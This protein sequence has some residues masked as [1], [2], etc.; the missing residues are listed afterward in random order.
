MTQRNQQLQT[1]VRLT[2]AASALAAAGVAYSQTAP[3][4]AAALE[5]VVITGSRL[6]TPNELSISPVIAVSAAD[7]QSRGVTRIEDMLTSLPQIYAAQN[8][9]VSNGADGT[10]TVSLRN[11]GSQR[12]LVLVNGRRLGPGDPGG[13]AADLNQIPTDLVERVE[14]LTG[15]ASSVYGADAV[16]GV[17]NFILNDH[18][19][20]FK[21]T[22]N[23]GFNNHSQHDPAGVQEVLANFNK[24]YNQD[25][26]AAPSN[27]N[28]GQT[29]EVSAVFGF[30]TGD[31]KGNVTSY[32]TYRN[33]AAVLQS[34]YDYSAATLGSGYCCS[35]SY[36][37]K[38]SVSGSSTSYPGRARLVN[39]FG[40]NQGGSKVLLPNAGDTAL[41]SWGTGNAYRFN[42]GP[43]NYQQR[44]DEQYTAGAMLH[45]EFNEHA[46]AYTEISYINDHTL[47]QI[48]PSGAF[49]GTGPYEV[50]CANPL[51]NAAEV[52]S[53]CGGNVNAG[54]IYLLLGRRNVEGGDRIDD[55][56]HSAWRV[57]QGLKGKINDAWDYD[58]YYSNSITELSET[59]LNDL[60]ISRLKN[61]LNVVTDT[62]VGSATY[63]Q[64]VC[65]SVISGSDPNCVPYNIWTPGQVTAAALK[66]ISTP[67]VSIGR[68]TQQMVSANVTG[69]LGKYGVKLPMAASGL[70]INFGAE[71]R[72][73]TSDFEPDFEY[74]S[75][76]AAGSGSP[77]LPVK[78]SVISREAFTEA[79]LPILDD[80]PFAKALALEGGYR[81]SD[82]SLGFQ[83]N[84]YKLGLEWSPVQELR[85]RGSFARA[86]RAPNISELY[87]PL[88]VG[89]DGSAD[90]CANS[91][92]GGA[93]SYTPAQCAALGV[94]AG[95]Y[96]TIDPNPAAQYN[97]YLGGNPN[98]K[99]ET[100]TTKSFG[101]GYSPTFLPGF[102]AQIDYYDIDIANTISRVGTSTIMAL[103][104]NAAPG[105]DVANTFCPEVHRDVNGSLWVS[106]D[107]YVSDPLNNNGALHEKGIDFD[108]SYS[109]DMRSMGK[110]RVSYVATKENSYVI[111]PLQSQPQTAFDCAGYYGNSC[112]APNFKWRHTMNALWSTPWRGV[113]VAMTWRYLGAVTVDSLSPNPNISIDGSTN[114]A[115][116]QFA[117]GLYCVSNTDAHLSSRSYLDLSASIKL[118]DHVS[119]RLGINNLFDKDPPVVG[120]SNIGPGN[121]NTFPSQY[122]ALGRYIFGTVTVQF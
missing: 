41:L 77:T 81:Y 96:G 56:T 67:L 24:T 10:A 17:V 3:A 104:A 27:V 64:P 53:F 7:I 2:L 79:R 35:S 19:E 113:D 26:Q 93:P 83:T 45:Y 70:K 51:F 4:P 112:G 49:Y 116:C 102:R 69:D 50:N 8:S 5:E 88:H 97:G 95:Q 54:N 60:S 68:T 71:W 110:M 111:T 1:A 91:A 100:A 101:V 22:T 14:V 122:D 37:G 9:A 28:T 18:F 6:S 103:C 75:G 74:Q 120:A 44:P 73:V 39:Q 94:S 114:P 11:L 33:I 43:L 118:Q 92:T 84:S 12:T 52:G 59:Y 32:A 34:K 85:I 36:D 25:F 20:G 58:A 42:Y 115:A 66:Y 38:F 87:A 76:D 30:N 16:A 13:S 82:Y 105:S 86:V 107:G 47:A 80:Q 99:P 106:N 48:A 46:N 61:A 62:R 63:G 119:L 108:F 57:V 109:F 40:V 31:G 29:K 55:L 117:P 72:E 98:L 15:G 23:Y 90:P 65:Q 89:L 78:G 121:G 21:L